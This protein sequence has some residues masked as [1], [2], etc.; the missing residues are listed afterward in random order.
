MIFKT[1][2]ILVTGGAGYIG[3]HTVLELLENGHSVSVVD[4]LS[5]SSK[6][7]IARVEKLSGKK[8]PLYIFDLCES[9]KLSNLFSNN[10][11]EAVVHFAGLK[12]VGDSV[13]DPLQYYENNLQS[14]LT[15]CKTMATHNVKTLIFSS[16]ATVYKQDEPS[17]WTEETPAGI[18]IGSP[19]GRTK[20]VAEEILHDI[21][22]ADDS[23]NIT[24]LRYFNPIGAHTSGELGENPIG[25]PNNLLPLVAEVAIGKRM[26]LIIFGD[27]YDTPDGTCIRDYIHVVDVARGHLAALET[28][29]SESVRTYNLGSG[30]G[31]SVLEVLRA[32]EQACG[33]SIPYRV[34]SR[35]P[36]DAPAYY[37][38][39]TKINEELGWS[40]KLSLADACRDTWNWQSKNPDGYDGKDII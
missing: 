24:I 40:T 35:R 26:E 7:S 14:T 5:N 34:T 16:S 23:W 9:D 25:T 38:D 17:P 36:G 2:N 15:L 10:T 6:E 30:K 3:T 20:Y 12:A 1:M 33:K 21:A 11:F 27:D 19:Y 28:R 39:P 8:V 13:S 29:G 37:A 32:F 4:N 18:S 31:S 22:I